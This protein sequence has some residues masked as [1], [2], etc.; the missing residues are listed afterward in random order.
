MKKILLIMTSLIMCAFMNCNVYGAELEANFTFSN[1]SEASVLTDDSHYTVANFSANDT[2]SISAVDGSKIYGIYIM[3]DS[4]I[5]DWT[6]TTDNGDISCGS[7]GF[8]HEYI[9]LHTPSS[10]V[11]IH[12]PSDKVR[13]SGIRIF[14][15][16]ELPHD[17]QVW[18]NPCEKADIMLIVS[19]S[20]DE[21]LFFGG[22]LPT[23]TYTYDADIQIVYMTQ[24]WNG[25]KIR[26]HEKLDGLWESGIRFYP[27][28]APFNDY[29]S[30]DIETAATQY[31]YE[32]MVEYVV[33]QIRCFKPQVILTHD[34]N[35]EYG[36][37]YHM[38]TC[39]AVMEAVTIASD[40]SQ[41]TD[42]VNSY[43]TFDVPKTYIHLYNE[44][45]ISLDY[46][47][48][49]DEDYADRTALAIATDAY[50][51]HV[52][53]QEWWFYVSDTYVYSCAKFG[54]WRT[55][56]GADTTDDLLCNIKTYKVQAEEEAK[57]RL[58]EEE[59]RQAEE[60]SKEAASIEAE[61]IEQ[62]SREAASIEAESI[63]EA[64]REAASIEQEALD[65]IAAEMA[66]TQEEELEAELRNMKNIT[67]AVVGMV[68][69]AITLGVIIL[70]IKIRHKK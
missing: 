23:Y 43:G 47:I 28:S 4:Q 44:N 68:I 51:K 6:L 31:D 29:K 2:I 11:T 59:S 48:P 55:T 1:D 56:V 53:Q 46:S 26:E 50:T 30:E 41:Y 14:S 37:G 33:R 70:T 9:A 54:L 61:S 60:A 7:N 67:Y 35:G 66:K 15:D 57:I 63:E 39:K 19:H 38:L 62:A 52:S 45:A 40:A 24:F 34:I 22:I 5:T 12:I 18:K 64:S 10:T 21:I 8:L 32:A 16:G 13:I 42:S 36:H 25:Q 65:A 69:I 3:W 20:D 27:V 58:A 49:L 17:V